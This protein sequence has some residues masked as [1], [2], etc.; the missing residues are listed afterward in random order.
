MYGVDEEDIIGSMP[1]I[2]VPGDAVAAAA[3]EYGA[4]PVVQ[5]AG[6]T[7]AVPGGQVLAGGPADGG[8][9][10]PQEDVGWLNG[11]LEI[12]TQA[13]WDALPEERKEVVRAAMAMG[14]QLPADEALKVYTG[15]RQRVLEATPQEAVLPDGSKAYVVNGQ[16]Y[17]ESD[18]AAKRLEAE[19]KLG[20]QAAA[21]RAESE[22]VGA[23]A[24]QVS[25]LGKF[26]SYLKEDGLVGPGAGMRQQVDALANPER[27]ARRRELEVLAKESVLQNLQLFK[28][29]ISNAEREYLER[30]YP[31]VSD[32]APVW[33]NY[34]TAAEE[35]FSRAA[36]SEGT[37]G[38]KGTKGTAGGAGGAAGAGAPAAVY[39]SAA[40]VKAAYKA[41]K[42]SREEA[43][44]ALRGMGMQ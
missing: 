16:T 2:P 37:D 22:R 5:D 14:G 42:V 1:E 3:S 10:P 36:G 19:R 8:M 38:T 41:G 6:G 24:A 30:M 29:A 13:E 15:A 39:K 9:V 12:R 32:P 18:L 28:G 25:R 40:E 20:E 23:A 4:Q 35:V 17:L 7:P 33:E 27:H 31:Q 44:A 11:T 26:R 43:V 21:D 34:M